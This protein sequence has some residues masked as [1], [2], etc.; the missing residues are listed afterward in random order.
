M[1]FITGIRLYIIVGTN[2]EVYEK[3]LLL[4]C[5]GF[6]LAVGKGIENTPGEQI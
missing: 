6:E 3:L 4:S 1:E 5:V 2:R